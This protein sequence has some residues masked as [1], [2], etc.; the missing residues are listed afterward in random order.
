MDK[1]LFKKCMTFSIS[2]LITC[3]IA[4]SIYFIY[5]N[6]EDIGILLINII[7]T[8]RPII[9]GLIIAFLINPIC[10]F[11]YNKFMNLFF[12]H[13]KHLSKNKA[14]MAFVLALIISFIV[15]IFMISAL[16][17]MII[18][19]IVQSIP[20]ITSNIST[21]YDNFLIFLQDNQDK[22]VFIML[23]NIF[24]NSNLTLDINELAQT[25]I[26]PNLEYLIQHLSLTTYNALLIG[27]DLLIGIIISVY[28]LLNKNNLKRQT[29]M[30]FIAIF[31][32]HTY[33]I[34]IDELK[35]INQVFNKF[36]VGKCI[37]SL[38]IGLI[39]LVTLSIFKI[40]YA[41]V[42]SV[43]VTITNVVPIF[44]PIIGAIPGFIL[45]LVTNP[46]KSLVFLILILIIQQID[47]HII[48]PKVLSGKIGIPTMWVLISII[49]FGH[50]FG[51]IGMIIGVPTFTVIYDLTRK[52]VHKKIKEKQIQESHI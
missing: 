44:G 29:N 49:V 20:I 13:K 43:I 16:F 27:K 23:Q 52:F 24:D 15:V 30:L 45:V 34:I 37:D 4:I 12:K 42:I 47:G 38:I 35:F 19:Q 10:N 26:S 17:M 39:T 5:K 46:I 11:F 33:D 6:L 31:N 8:F 28:V 7:E 51:I 18:P 14:R 41:L 1:K 9:Y 32:K 36:I 22:S 50:M 21:A 2:I 48:G 25:Y 3:I 40:P